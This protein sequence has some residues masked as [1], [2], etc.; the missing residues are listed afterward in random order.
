MYK[1][2]YH[3]LDPH[4]ILYNLQFGFRASHSI[5]HALVS[6]TESIKNSLDN[7]HFG[8]GLFMDLQ[9]AFDTVN[10]QT[11][12][13][14][15]KHHGIRGMA[16]TWFS[17]YLSNR[18]Q[19]VSVNGHISSHHKITCGVPQGSVLGPLLFLIYINDLPK[20][21]KKLSFYLFADD[22][23]IYFESENLSHLEKLVN[24]ELKHVKK[25]LDVNKL[26]LN[27]DKT[28]FII[29][30]SR[31]RS[32]SKPVNIKIGKEHVKQAKYV[33]VVGLLLDENFSWRYHLSELR[34]KLARTSGIFFKIRL[35]LPTSVLVSLYYSL[36]ASFLQ[37]GIIVWGLT[38]DT[39]TKPLY[40]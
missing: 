13:N 16:L 7:K 26:A 24:N 4:K 8:C 22:T 32:L 10:H 3:C 17:S 40:I 20:S 6:L 23:N 2:L 35:L 27:V 37:Y 39:F 15:R 1:R 19:C 34:K 14:K 12:L 36:F 9:K 21:S 38:Y 29:F 5:N 25:W 31:Q 11:L 30:H 33:K 28:N 18:T